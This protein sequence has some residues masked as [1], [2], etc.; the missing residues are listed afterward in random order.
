MS[1]G[2]FTEW[3]KRL[4]GIL[5]SSTN[6]IKRLDRMLSDIK[7]AYDLPNSRNEQAIALYNRVKKHLLEQ[8][9]A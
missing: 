4:Q 7:E 8:E 5:K 6:K 1:Y 2:E 3:E 9:V